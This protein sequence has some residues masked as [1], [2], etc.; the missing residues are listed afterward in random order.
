MLGRLRLT[1]S[2]CILEYRQLS[3][4]IVRYGSSR[5]PLF[6]TSWLLEVAWDIIERRSKGGLFLQAS[7]DASKAKTY[8]HILGSKT[9]L[10]PPRFVF[11]VAKDGHV[12]CFKTYKPHLNTD[13]TSTEY[14]EPEATLIS[15]VFAALCYDLTRLAM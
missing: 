6:D 3:S 15:D 1:I 13:Q 5:P 11:A 14:F 4:Q 10:T 12:C 8:D 9:I 2:E 7:K